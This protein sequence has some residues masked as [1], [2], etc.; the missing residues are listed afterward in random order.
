LL[1]ELVRA[2]GGIVSRQHLIDAVW[3]AHAVV[4]DNTLDVAVSALRRR[5]GDLSP[6]LIVRAV[7]GQGVQLLQT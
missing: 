4:S 6:R 7:R 5:L 1:G 3:G 2:R